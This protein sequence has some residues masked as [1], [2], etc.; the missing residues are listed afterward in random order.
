MNE[1]GYIGMIVNGFIGFLQ[2]NMW[3]VLALFIISMFES[4]L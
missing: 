2:V 3:L 4:S 1:V